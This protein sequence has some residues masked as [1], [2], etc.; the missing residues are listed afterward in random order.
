MN[1]ADFPHKRL[2]PLT[3]DWVLISPHRTKRPWQERIEQGSSPAVPAYDT[4]CF[5]CPGN[6]RAGNARNPHYETTFAFDNDLSALLPDIPVESMNERNLLV[7]R[8]ERGLCRVICHSPRH[9][10]SLPLLSTVEISSI[11]DAW[12]NEFTDSC[13]NEFAKYVLI[14]ENRGDITGAGSSHPHSQAWSTETIPTVPALETARQRE[15][16]ERT[17]SCLLCDYVKLEV[18]MQSRLIVTNEHFA[19]VSPFWAVW[20]H[21]ALVIPFGHYADIASMPKT[22]R[23]DFADILNKLT[24]RYDNLFSSPFPYSM[25]I[26]QRPTTRDDHSPWHC[27]AHFFSPVARSLSSR[28]LMAGYEVLAMPHRDTT[29]EDAARRLRNCSEVHHTKR[30]PEDE[31][32]NAE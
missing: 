1:L 26:H 13:D 10:L 23:E 6:Q 3:G 14:F 9:D 19:A 31:L 27:H 28:K 4:K 21:E 25:G 18:Q 32:R 20:P 29:P 30:K 24:I 7:A 15:Y 17:G 5:L 11:V 22:V 2:N 16:A 12:A 8:G